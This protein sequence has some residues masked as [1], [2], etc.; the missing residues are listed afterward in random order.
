MTA[1]GEFRKGN[2]MK[3][4]AI[5]GLVRALILILGAL[6]VAGFFF[7]VWSESI[8]GKAMVGVPV[9]LLMLAAFGAVVAAVWPRKG[10]SESGDPSV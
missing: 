1:F 10:K 5:F 2:S 6:A 7:A 4:E 3:P 9:M 8:V